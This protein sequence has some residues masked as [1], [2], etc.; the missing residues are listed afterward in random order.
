MQLYNRVFSDP[1][2]YVVCRCLYRG[3][4]YVNVVVSVFEIW[5]PNNRYKTFSKAYFSQNFLSRTSQEN[6]LRRHKASI[7]IFEDKACKVPIKGSF[8]AAFISLVKTLFISTSS[9]SHGDKAWPIFALCGLAIWPRRIWK[10]RTGE[11]GTLFVAEIE[12]KISKRDCESEWSSELDSCF[13]QSLSY[14]NQCNYQ[15]RN[16]LSSIGRTELS[17]FCAGIH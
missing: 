6:L 17:F 5:A 9:L 16:M 4:C 12:L 11:T 7:K 10:K 2:S 14:K 3:Q 15:Y 8:F 13:K 1:S